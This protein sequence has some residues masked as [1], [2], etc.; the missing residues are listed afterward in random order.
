MKKT[1]T[2]LAAIAAITAWSA[3]YADVLRMAYSSAPRSV[4][5][6]PFG[7]A[8]TAAYKEHIYEALV[9]HDDSPLLATGWTWNSPTSLTVNLRKGVNFHNGQPFTARDVVYSAC[10]MM[11]LI[12]GKRNLLTSSM[13]P[14]TDVVAV[15][16]HNVRFE[17]AN[18]YPLWIQK[19]KFLSILPTSGASVPDG[20]IKYDAQGDCGITAY[21]TRDDFENGDAAIGTGPFKHVSFDKE[22]AKMERNDDYWG[23]VAQW[24]GVEITSVSNSG[25]RFAGL[26]AG[27]Y[28]LIEN[29][30]A[31]DITALSTNDDYTF[32]GK[33]AWRTMFIV[34][35]VSPDGASG[36]SAADGSAPLADIRVRQAMSLAI[37]REAITNRLL[38]GSATVANQ[39]APAYRAGAPKMPE[40]KYDPERAKEL[41]ADAGYTDGFTIA[42]N[43]PSDRYPSGTRV[44]QAIA[45]YWSRIGINVEL[46]TQPWSVFAKARRAGELGVF[47]YGWGHP[48][49]PAQMIS[50]AFASRNTELGLG[51]S[52]YSNYASKAFDTAIQAW[53][54]EPDQAKADAYVADAMV[55]AMNDLPGIPIYYTHSLWA[56]RS[57]LTVDGRQDERTSSFMVSK[58]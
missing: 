25:A 49:G 56:H 41:L 42:F 53:A 27:D 15:D 48:Q 3:A 30:T 13:G 8:T 35:N 28:D 22:F 40:L 21:P 55:A 9:A 1:I 14:L 4:D 34:L 10:R 11:N 58:N 32:T 12:D 45:Q 24:E 18:P 47:L 31:E 19:M 6:Y 39:F 2:I 57:D 37:N 44:A 46:K 23:K 16:D 54:V 51:S 17:M 50:F 7:G 36:V 33:P 26:L 52:N 29:P 20:P 38:G 5:P 43:A